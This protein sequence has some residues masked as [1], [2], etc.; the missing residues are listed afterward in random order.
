MYYFRTIFYI[1][2]IF[3]YF[4]CLIKEDFPKALILVADNELEQ[5]NGD[6]FNDFISIKNFLQIEHT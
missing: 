3:N 2:T 5:F 4:I 6:E 1:I